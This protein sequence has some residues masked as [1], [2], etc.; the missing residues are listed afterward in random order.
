[1]EVKN[2]TMFFNSS[3][4]TDAQLVCKT[5]EQACPIDKVAAELQPSSS[6][7]SSAASLI[8]T[9]ASH[10]ILFQLT[11]PTTLIVGLFTVLLSLF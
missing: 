3:T 10:G 8:S 6:P 2:I 9:V 5:A 7:S 1:M 11:Q 4:A